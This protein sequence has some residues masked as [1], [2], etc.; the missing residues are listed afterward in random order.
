MTKLRRPAA[1][2]AALILGLSLAMVP[3]E[4]AAFP[5]KWL[6]PP[7]GFEIGDPDT[8]PERPMTFGETWHVLTV[9][10]QVHIVRVHWGFAARKTKLG[11]HRIGLERAE[12]RHE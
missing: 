2:M 9:S 12:S 5:Y 6:E 1:W 4:G 10:G 11:T 7:G 8:P 3:R